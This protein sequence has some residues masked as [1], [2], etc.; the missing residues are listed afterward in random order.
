MIE[1]E[2]WHPVALA[3][4]VGDAPVPARL[5]GEDLVLWR[6]AQGRVHAWQDRCP[7]RGA[8]L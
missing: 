5:L 8:Q 7:H 1:K 6:D 4:G 2:L 3:A